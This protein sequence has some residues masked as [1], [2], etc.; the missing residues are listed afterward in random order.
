MSDL[1]TYAVDPTEKAFASF[2]DMHLAQQVAES[3]NKRY[4]GHLWAVAIPEN[5]GIIQVRDLML[6]GEWGFIIKLSDFASASELDKLAMRYGGELLER[7]NVARRGTNQ[8]E[9]A[10]LPTDFSGRHIIQH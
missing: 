10:M 1:I 8:A 2:N 6:S 5:Q 3:L 7:Y 9:I 4:P